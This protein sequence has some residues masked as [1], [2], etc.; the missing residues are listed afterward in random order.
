[1]PLPQAPGE[2]VVEGASV[3]LPAV[4]DAE[5]PREGSGL[6][7]WGVAGWAQ[8]FLTCFPEWFLCPFPRRG[9]Q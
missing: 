8:V 7:R 1:M 3:G 9:D 5:C 6:A 4:L 2:E